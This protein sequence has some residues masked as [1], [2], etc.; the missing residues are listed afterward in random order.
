MTDHGDDRDDDPALRALRAVWLSMP[1]EEP[2]ERGLAELMAAARVK[3]EQMAQPSWWQRVFAVLRRPPM[4]ALATVMVLIGGAVFISKRS[5]KLEAPP[6][7]ATQPQRQL[8]APPPSAT[9]TQRQLEAPVVGSAVQTAPSGNAPVEMAPKPALE[10]TRD[11][12]K[13]GASQRPVRRPA[14]KTPAPSPQPPPAREEEKAEKVTGAP[15]SNVDAR[16]QSAPSLAGEQVKEAAPTTE[17]PNAPAQDRGK[18]QTPVSQYFSQARS[19]ATRGD[20]AAAR[21]LA[22]RIAKQDA[23]YYRDVVVNDSALKKC[24]ATE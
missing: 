13:G 10:P 6:P 7:S 20:C 3:A 18:S 5:D 22:G 1:D 9:E 8:E 16:L 4:L 15:V 2:P 23:Q 11:A 17:S 24:L 14:A 21:V 12:V 19:A